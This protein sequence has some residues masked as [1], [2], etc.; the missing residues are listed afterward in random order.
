[1][2]KEKIILDT[3]IYVSALGWEGKPRQILDRAIK[4]EYELILSVKQLGEIKRVLDYPKLGFTEDQKQR[5]LAILHE[6]AT[7]VDTKTTVNT[8]T[9][10]PAD[11]VTLE[12]AA[13]MKIDCIVTGDEHMLKLKEFKGAQII[14]ISQ[15]PEKQ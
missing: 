2:G 7:T 13:E 6:I 10:D 12:P 4:G 3:N 15:F 1:M 11:N 9:E 14:K 8:I 5:F